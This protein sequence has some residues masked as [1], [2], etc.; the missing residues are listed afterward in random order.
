MIFPDDCTAV[1][2]GL[3][4]NGGLCFDDEPGGSVTCGCPPGFEGQTCQIGMD[5]AQSCPSTKKF[6]GSL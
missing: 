6:D 2:V 1:S 3:C 5:I 4:E